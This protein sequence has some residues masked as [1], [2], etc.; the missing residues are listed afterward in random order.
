[1]KIEINNRRKVLAIQ[2]EFALAFPDLRIEFYE[3]PSKP[4]GSPSIKLMKSGGKTLTECRA[5]HNE[6]VITIRPGM[7]VGEVKGN[8]SD[9]F[10]LSVEILQNTKTGE[11]KT[12]DN[13]VLG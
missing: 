9:V 8:F 7:T 3:K 6:G 10:G 13:T 11:E 4:G 12:M 1:M 2:E 5:V